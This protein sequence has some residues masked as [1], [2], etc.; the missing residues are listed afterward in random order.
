MMSGSTRSS[1]SAG[2]CAVVGSERPLWAPVIAAHALRRVVT[3]LLQ[4]RLP[5]LGTW[6]VLSAPNPIC[7][8]DSGGRARHV[9]KPY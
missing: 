1:V 8:G 9:T 7:P 4:T 6:K 3:L 5:V 2:T